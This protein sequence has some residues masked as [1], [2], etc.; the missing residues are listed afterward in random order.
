[1][2]NIPDPPKHLRTGNSLVKM[3]RLPWRDNQAIF[4]PSLEGYVLENDVVFIFIDSC[5][6]ANKFLRKLTGDSK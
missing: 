6:V 4:I 1:M 5:N 2:A 3:E